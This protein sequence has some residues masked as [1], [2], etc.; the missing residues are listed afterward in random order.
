VTVYFD[1]KDR[2]RVQ[3]AIRQVVRVSGEGEFQP[4]ANEP[5]KIWASSI[6]VIYE[7][8]ALDVDAFWREPDID[9]LGRK[10]GVREYALPPGVETDPWR[11]ED[12]AA[13][14]I[15]AIRSSE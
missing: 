9:Q 1:E 7:T 11:D 10:Q 13:A 6:E 8:L 15:H 12:E 3:S 4:E 2:D 5:T 14:F